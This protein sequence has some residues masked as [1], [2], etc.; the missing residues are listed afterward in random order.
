[1]NY[2]PTPTSFQVGMV[3]RKIPVDRFK[4]VHLYEKT[5]AGAVPD[6]MFDTIL[7]SVYTVG[8]A[9]TFH[10]L[11]IRVRTGTNAGGT[12]K[13]YQGDTEDAITSLKF[14][15]ELH[16]FIDEWQDFPLVGEPHFGGIPFDGGKFIV[17]DPS[18]SQ[19]DWIEMVGYEI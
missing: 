10:L 5:N 9:R 8:V 16:K 17:T 12:V 2:K 7:G 11:G 15:C 6:S 13:V 1:M 18:T 19:V 4:E 14:T 3:S